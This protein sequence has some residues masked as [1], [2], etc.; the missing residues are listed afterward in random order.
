MPSYQAPPI[1]RSARIEQFSSR[2]CVFALKLQAALAIGPKALLA[3]KQQEMLVACAADHGDADLLRDLV[4]HLSQSGAR[5][6]ELDTHLR[7]LDHHLG[8]EP[9]R[10]IENLVAAVDAIEPHATGN[11]V[12]RIVTADVFD[13]VQY[14]TGAILV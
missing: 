8:S 10:G 6:Q 5:D 3:R 2:L 14:L 12:N 4:T 1:S 7:S 13:E 9:A 11:G